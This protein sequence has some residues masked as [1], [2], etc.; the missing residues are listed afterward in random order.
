MPRLSITKLNVDVLQWYGPSC[1]LR[2]YLE[3]TKFIVRTDHDALRWIL[4]L[5]NATGRLARWCLRLSEFDFS[6][7][8][9]PG[10][11]NKATDA[12]SRLITT[13]G[14]TTPLDL[15]IPVVAAMDTV[16]G[17]QIE[18]TQEELD[19][20][21]DNDD[22]SDERIDDESSVDSLNKLPPP[23]FEP[24]SVQAILS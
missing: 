5:S 10:I 1:L 17:D 23:T 22:N 6:V 16:E 9:K 8:Y 18:P 15:S 2:S 21:D 24:I 11:K 20:A 19:Y 7:E 13:G 14:D 3:G 12:F 4:D